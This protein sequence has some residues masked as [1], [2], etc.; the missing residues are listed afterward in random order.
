MSSHEALLKHVSIAAKDST[1][2][3]TFDIDG[4]IPGS[5]PTWWGSWQPRRTIRINA[6]W[7]SSS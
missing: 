6:G 7:E 2:V 5:A 1:L 4:N 3:A